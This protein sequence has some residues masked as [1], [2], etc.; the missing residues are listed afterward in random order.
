MTATAQASSP[1]VQAE[2]AARTSVLHA[3]RHHSQR[4]VRLAPGALRA[5]KALVDL[6]L[7][8][9]SVP[10]QRGP[11]ESEDEAAVRWLAEDWRFSLR[12]AADYREQLGDGRDAE[13]VALLRDLHLSLRECRTGNVI[14]AW[15]DR[16][17]D[18]GLRIYGW[19]D[20]QRPVLKLSVAHRRPGGTSDPYSMTARTHRGGTGPATITLTLHLEDF[21]PESYA[22]LPRLLAHECLCHA[23]GGHPRRYAHNDSIFAEGWVDWAVGEIFPHWAGKWDREFA[24]IAVQHGIALTEHLVQRD[25]GWARAVGGD[26]AR[27]IARWLG[28][29]LGDDRAGRVATTRLAFALNLASGSLAIKDE[30]TE[31][32]ARGSASGLAEVTLS[33]HDSKAEAEDIIAAVGT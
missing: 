5:E 20:W 13:A 9:M 14:D 18:L 32:L 7:A 23:V 22:A 2:I 19:E 29:E 4:L 27:S 1:L 21:G 24:D 25:S 15:F 8:S 6:R 26:H 12:T 16:I 17:C 3:V 30:I 28:R 33:W 10:Q 31:Q 11:R